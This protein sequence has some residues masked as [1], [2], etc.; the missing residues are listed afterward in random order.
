MRMSKPQKRSG[1]SL[2]ELLVVISLIALLAGLVASAVFRIKASQAINNTE[3]TLGKV[4][5][6]LM[7]RWSAVVDQAKST[8]PA[9]LVER[10]GN[11][12]DR[13]TALWTMACLKNEFPM[14]FAEANATINLGTDAILKPRAI[15]LKLVNDSTLSSLTAEQQSAALIYVALTQ[16]GNKGLNNGMDGLE[17]Q[18]GQLTPGSNAT[19][20]KDSWGQPLIFQRHLTN[21]EI[22]GV[23]YTRVSSTKVTVNGVQTLQIKNMLD[24]LSKL[25]TWK[26]NSGNVYTPANQNN[27]WLFLRTINPTMQS[28]AMGPTIDN[29]TYIHQQLRL[30]GLTATGFAA[31]PDIDHRTNTI[32]AFLSAG[33]NKSLGSAPHLGVTTGDDEGNDNLLSFR[34]RQEGAR[35]N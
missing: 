9:S 23:P 35:G 17:G 2:I 34:T 26:N 4:D 8:V 6:L 16:S 3:A 15:F 13:A 32:P 5:R 29:L 27:P 12:K 21:D 11:D 25:S 20:F 19:V 18:T 10:C 31:F 7:A 30:G 1:F 28:P 14:T 22:N 33:Q 24:P